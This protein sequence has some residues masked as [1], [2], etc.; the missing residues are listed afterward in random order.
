M[1]S[2]I[3]VF[4]SIVSIFGKNKKNMVAFILLN[5][6]CYALSYLVLGGYSGFTSTAV[7]II[8]HILDLK[9]KLTKFNTFLICTGIIFL[10]ILSNEN[11]SLGLLPITAEVSFAILAYLVKSSQGLRIV[12]IFATVQWAIFDFYIQAYRTFLMDIII[13]ITCALEYLRRKNK[14]IADAS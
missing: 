12:Y 5:D 13:I 6:S 2:A 4:F 1:L 10:G 7:L 9:G 14:N 8:R 11:S 3:G